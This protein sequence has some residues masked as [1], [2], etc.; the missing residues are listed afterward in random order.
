MS[1]FRTGGHGHWGAFIAA[2]VCVVILGACALALW[3]VNTEGRKRISEQE[4]DAVSIEL[5]LFEQILTDDGMDGLVRSVDR[6][7]DLEGSH[8][9]YALRDRDGRMLSGALA[10]WPQG[11]KS[12]EDWTPI[13]AEG[14][15]MDVSTR[16][17]GN[18]VELMI[19]RDRNALEQFQ[20][21]VVESVWLAIALVM[22]A[23]LL[24]GLALASYILV[25]VRSL[26]DVAARVSTGDFSARALHAD[27]RGPF[28]QIAHAQNLMLDRIED[29]VTGLRS[30][31][32]SLAHDLRTPLGQLRRRIDDGLVAET[33]SDKQV[34]LEDASRIADKTISTFTALIDIARAD[35]GL[36]RE[37]MTSV[38]LK[39]MLLDVQSLFEPM[40]EDKGQTLSIVDIQP[41]TIK[42][43]KPLLMQAASNLVHNAIKYAP[44]NGRVEIS[45]HDAADSVEIVVADNGPGIPAGQRGEALQRFHRVSP[46]ADS[47][48][49]G[50]GLAIVEACARL[51]GGR[52]ILDDNTPGL[53]ARLVLA[54]NA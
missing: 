36:S 38:D 6:V 1:P 22:T 44:K 51:H 35:G 3:I 28:G 16:Q 20:S 34:A 15:T 26:S 23:C 29:L 12:G 7:A 41:V 8:S 5:D 47:E 10:A 45:L 13:S 21:R 4:R 11:L 39:A 31:T 2:G 17:F 27:D 32:D 48:G 46:T 40:A 33:P 53:K 52:V 30:V 24:A 54:R 14:F 37:A 18:G 19:G 50:L 43:H 49:H 42:G 9:I 25:R